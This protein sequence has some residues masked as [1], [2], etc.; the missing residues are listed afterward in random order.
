MSDSSER[1]WRNPYLLPPESKSGRFAI[2]GKPVVCPHCGSE[3]FVLSKARVNTAALLGLDWANLPTHTLLCAQC[4]R[5]EWFGQ[6][7][8]A[9]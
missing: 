8:D 5:I 7:P 6:E 1:Q 3:E 4:A 9:V 2:G